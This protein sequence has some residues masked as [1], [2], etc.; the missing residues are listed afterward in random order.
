LSAKLGVHRY[1]LN[2]SPRALEILKREATRRKV[3]WSEALRQILVEFDENSHTHRPATSDSH[4]KSGK[5]FPDDEV[6]P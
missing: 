6:E 1:Q 3:S 2:L 4:R 5:F